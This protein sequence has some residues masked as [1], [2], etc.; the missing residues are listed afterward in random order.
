M[1]ADANAKLGNAMMDVVMGQAVR[2]KMAEARE[3][4]KAYNNPTGSQRPEA[5]DDRDDEEDYMD[6]DE[7]EIFEQMKKERLQ[8]VREREQY[9][10]EREEEEKHKKENLWYGEYTEI[11]EQE[12]LPYVTKAE[13]SVCHFFHKDFERCKI[14]DK[15]LQIIAADHKECKFLKLD[16]EKTPFFVNKLAVKVLPTI[17]LFKKGVLVDQVVGFEELGGRDDFKTVILSRRLVQSGVIK[18]KNKAEKGIRISRGG[19]GSDGD[20][21]DDDF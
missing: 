4:E 18:A 12:F 9:R 13:Y 1:D 14:I 21:S 2:D 16:A 6:E 5:A 8:E 15:H 10:E 7:K 3:I 20:S 19:A 17:C 11:V